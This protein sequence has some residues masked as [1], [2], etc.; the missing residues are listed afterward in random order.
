MTSDHEKYDDFS[1]CFFGNRSQKFPALELCSIKW[2][3]LTQRGGAAGT[4]SQLALPLHGEY[5]GNDTHANGTSN[6]VNITIAQISTPSTFASP[7]IAKVSQNFILTGGLTAAG[8]GV[9]TRQQNSA[10][11]RQMASI[12]FMVPAS[13][14]HWQVRGA[15]EL[16]STRNSSVLLGYA[17]RYLH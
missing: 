14:L 15:P 10:Q 7:P 9:A 3:Q 6:V 1:R 12:G 11:R 17:E 2:R 5:A 4:R 8:N 13:Q 16:C